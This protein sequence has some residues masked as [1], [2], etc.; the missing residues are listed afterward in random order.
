MAGKVKIAKRHLRKDDFNNRSLCN[1]LLADSYFAA[2]RSDFLNGENQ[3]IPCLNKFPHAAAD[4]S[5]PPVSE[6]IIEIDQETREEET[7]EETKHE[8]LNQEI[9]TQ[10]ELKEKEPE[11]ESKQ[12]EE[13]QKETT[14]KESK[15]HEEPEEAS[16]QEEE[17]KEEEQKETTH[18]QTTQNTKS[19]EDELAELAELQRKLEELDAQEKEKK[20]LA[21]AAEKAWLAEEEEK[22]KLQKLAEAEKERQRKLAEEEERQSKLAEEKEKLAEQESLPSIIEKQFD[23]Q[24]IKEDNRKKEAERIAADKKIEAEARE[25][26]RIIYLQKLEVQREA[27]SQKKIQKEKIE[28]HVNL[29]FYDHRSNNARYYLVILRT[30]KAKVK[31]FSRFEEVTK[32]LELQILI[33][34]PDKRCAIAIIQYSEDLAELPLTIADFVRMMN[35]NSD[36]VFTCPEIDKSDLVRMKIELID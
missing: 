21:E 34:N 22:E 24:K 11:E 8:A 6:I 12:E 32:A 5:I 7:G 35:K 36:F 18:D 28:N 2:S 14:E 20:A 23:L 4:R 3:C 15:Q 29:C 10:E 17:L 9:S 25:Q 19:L 13:Q 26:K 1:K 16:N 30:G 33:C 27:E 31:F